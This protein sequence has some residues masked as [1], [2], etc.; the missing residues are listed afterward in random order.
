MR[1]LPHIACATSLLAL[2]G[3]HGL[4]P[5]RSGDP[6]VD[7]GAVPSD[8]SSSVD[9]S[10]PRDAGAGPSGSPDAGLPAEANFDS[11]G[12]SGARASC[13]NFIDDDM[14]GAADC[15]APTC[16]DPLVNTACCVASTASA[17]C[18]DAA[19][20][21]VETRALACSGVAARCLQVAGS[22]LVPTL[23]TVYSSDLLPGTCSVM[24]GLGFAPLGTDSS[25]GFLPLPGAYAPASSYITISGRIGVADVA[26]PRVAAAGFGLFAPQG[27][28]AIARPLVG[29]V[30]SATSNDVRVI[31]GDRV[32]HTEPLTTDTC[33]RS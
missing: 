19:P 11:S 7:A 23:G 15:A 25:H 28:G 13:F 30:A 29:V 27:L 6:T 16:D 1:A 26:D 24:P 2:V 9:A 20:D 21:V 3:C 5:F 17:C 31:V 18:V 32:I 14:N 10:A 8:A 33:G 22:E 12:G 4:G